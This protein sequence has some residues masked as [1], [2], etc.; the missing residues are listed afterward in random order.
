MLKIADC[1]PLLLKNRFI[2]RKKYTIIYL[3]ETFMVILNNMSIFFTYI[4]LLEISL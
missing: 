2:K 4:I 1:L 3:N